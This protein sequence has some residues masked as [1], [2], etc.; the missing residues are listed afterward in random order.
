MPHSSLRPTPVL[1]NSVVTTSG[2]TTSFA[3]PPAVRQPMSNTTQVTE[4]E[5][6]FDAWADHQIKLG[7]LSVESAADYKYLWM[8]YVGWCVAQDSAWCEVQSADILRFLAG[9]SPGTGTGRRRALNPHRMSHY[10][11]QRYWRLLFGVYT[12]AHKTQRIAHN[13]AMDVDQDER[14]SIG[15]SDRQSQVLE[16]FVFDKL[17]QPAVIKRLFTAKSP[18][19]WWHARDCAILA[20]LVDTGITVSELITLRGMDLVS[21]AQGRGP[22]KASP[23][24]DLF[25]QAL[26]PACVM[27]IM[28]TTTNVGRTLAI[29]SDYAPLVRDWLEWR[30]RLLNERSAAAAALSQRAGFM[31]M[32]GAQG[33]LFFARRARTGGDLF[34]AMAPGSV[35]HCVSQALTTLR[36]LE[37]LAPAP[38]SYVA[39]G[40]AVI[41]NTVIRRWIDE[42]GVP[43]AVNRAGLK[44]V[45]SLRLR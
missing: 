45:Y 23:Q 3:G 37:N 8:A 38:D 4:A 10:T 2:L 42:H 1:A 30:Q 39:S 33:P 21:S 5:Q 11:R 41:R 20:V 16:P 6:A 14:P 44:D 32:H 17:A 27:D 12:H 18:D 26:E 29:H 24:Q 40:A 22:L 13:P 28:E 43:E 15:A 35:Y 25:S 36:E 19:N 9:P 7:E 34:P 31:A